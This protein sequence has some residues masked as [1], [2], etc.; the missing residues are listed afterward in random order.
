SVGDHENAALSHCVLLRW[1]GCACGTPLFCRRS[2]DTRA[3]MCQHLV[4]PSL[5]GDWGGLTGDDGEAEV[6]GRRQHRLNRRLS[7][8]IVDHHPIPDAAAS[9]FELRLD[10]HDEL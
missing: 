8:R 10:Q 4:I 7:F 5:T 2:T 3:K 9:D 6:A 1:V